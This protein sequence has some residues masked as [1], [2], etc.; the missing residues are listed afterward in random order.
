MIA[1]LLL[2]LDRFDPC[3][4]P[5]RSAASGFIPGV[6][7]GP[8][9]ERYLAK[10]V[11]RITLPGVFIAIIASSRTCCGANVDLRPPCE[12]PDLGRRGV[13]LMRQIDSQLTLR[14]YEGF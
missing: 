8:Q 1:C 2:Q 10:I 3:A 12:H 4:R 7:P 5:T 14:N 13:E 9:T 11:N 6:R